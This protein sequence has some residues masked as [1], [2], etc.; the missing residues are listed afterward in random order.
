MAEQTT[1]SVPAVKASG[2]LDAFLNLLSLITVVWLAYSV[3][4]VIFQLINKFMG[5]LEPAYGYANVN[6]YALKLSIASLIV[7]APV[8]FAVLNILHKN[9]KKGVLDHASGVYRWLTYLMLLISAL[10]IIGSFIALI[11]G[12]LN[13]NY[14]ANFISKSLTVA[15]I[16]G[17]I[18][19]YYFFDLKRSA[20]DKIHAVSASIGGIVGLVIITAVIMG[21]MNVPTPETARKQL[22]DNQKTQALANMYSYVID[23]YR[24]NGELK[25]ELAM[26]Q[27]ENIAA[28][29][30]YADITYRLIDGNNF[31]LCALFLAKA[32]PS[33]DKYYA[34]PYNPSNPWLNH[35]AGRQCYPFNVTKEMEK[36]YPKDPASATVE[37]AV[38]PVVQPIN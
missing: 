23:T 38:A 27:L 13:G 14:T 16:A 4:A 3:G 26:A 20:Y 32:E 21:F 6:Y 1:P 31:E 10:T 12:F 24:S 11:S 9:Y 22:L 8:Y 18:F 30:T 25:A 36:M 29:G 2:A 28:P 33:Y 34:M 17:F 35:E 5:N 7:V 37:P 19:G 15:T